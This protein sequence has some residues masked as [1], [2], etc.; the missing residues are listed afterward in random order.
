MA[1]AVGAVGL[2]AG[3]V[4][5]AVS[6]GVGAVM[7]RYDLEGECVALARTLALRVGLV[8]G[9]AAVIMLLMVAGLI[10]M[11]AQDEAR[12]RTAEDSPWD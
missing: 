9:A 4:V 12:R 1:T 6:A 3:I 7:C 10:R 11:A 8:A 5:A 2:L